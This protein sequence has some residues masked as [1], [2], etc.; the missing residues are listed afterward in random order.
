M[1]RK[2]SK[3]I[4]A[5]LV[6]LCLSSSGVADIKIK[7]RLTTKDA[8]YE[9]TLYLKGARQRNEMNGVFRAR[10]PRKPYDVAFLEQCDLKQLVHLDL[11]NKHYSVSSGGLSAGEWMAFGELQI[12]GNEDAANQ[13]KA[14]S[15]GLLTETLTVTDTGERRNMFGF[16]ARHIKIITTWVA[17]PK[18]CKGPE[19]KIETDGWYVDLLYGIDCSPDLSGSTSRR[20][21]PGGK[22]FAEYANKRSY[23]RERKR[24]GPLPLG[25]PLIEIITSYNDKGEAQVDTDEVLELSTAALD[26][27]LFDVPAGFTKFDF[28]ADNRS[29]FR[30]LFSFIGK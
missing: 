26:A 29:F 15:R 24:S 14:R 7:R 17:N 3:M 27:S 19:M 1:R 25:F 30:R 20:L 9:S 2:A 5:T 6:V 23:W 18:T 28:T 10:G 8:T 21:L 11:T 16:T 4:V 22:C 13:A 12:P